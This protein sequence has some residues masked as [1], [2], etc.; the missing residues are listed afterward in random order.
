MKRKIN[1]KIV[2]L[3]SGLVVAL[4]AVGAL[5][6]FTDVESHS[7]EATAGNF[8]IG[9]VDSTVLDTDADGILNPGDTGTVAFDITN[10]GEKSADVQAVIKVVSSVPMTED[11]YEYNIEGAGTP[12]VS[13]DKTTLTYTVDLGTVN[14]SIETESGIETTEA[15]GSYT[16][17]FE[18]AA[19]N[20]FQDSDVEVSYTIYAKQHRNTTTEDWANAETVF[21][22]VET[23]E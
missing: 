4:S 14:G 20:S 15:S 3:G 2:A 11:A 1:K 19:K 8:G 5:A 22:H 21:E 10:E 17:N 6:Y 16:F 9:S 18:K 7:V 23:I 13:E 12:E